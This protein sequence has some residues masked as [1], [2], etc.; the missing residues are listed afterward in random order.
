MAKT[1]AQKGAAPVVIPVPS[2]VTGEWFP[3]SV[4]LPGTRAVLRMQ[5][6]FATPEG[7]YLYS[8]VPAVPAQSLQAVPNWFSPINYELT[9]A[10]PAAQSQASKLG[11]QIQTEAGA[12]MIQM[13]GSC[14]CGAKSL[15]DWLPVWGTSRLEWKAPA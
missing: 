1:S 12:V 3:A 11:F 9:A 15:R 5:R 4:R 14:P 7:L 10:P 13:V 8:K 6:V 2:G